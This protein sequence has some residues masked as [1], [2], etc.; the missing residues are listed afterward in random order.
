[1][2]QHPH[3]RYGGRPYVYARGVSD[4]RLAHRRIQHWVLFVYD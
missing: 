2:G 3:D 4:L 1:M